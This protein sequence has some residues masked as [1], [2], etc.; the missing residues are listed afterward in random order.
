MSGSRWI[1]STIACTTTSGRRSAAP[2]MP[3]IAVRQRTHRVEDVRHRADAAVEG[4]VRLGRGRVAVPER[5]DDPARRRRGRPAR[6]RPGAPA[7]SVTSRTGPASSRRS[8]SVGSGS[9]RRSRGCVPSRCGEMKGPSRWAPR[10]RAPARM[11]R[12]RAQRGGELV[13]ARRDERRQVAGDA[14]LE[15][16]L[17]RPRRSRPRRRRGSRRRANPFTCRSTKPGAAM[18]RPGAREPDGG[19]AAVVDRDVAG[20][21]PPVDAALPRLR[22]SR[23]SAF[24]TTPPAASSRARAVVGVDTGEQRDDRDARVP[25]GR[26]ERRLDPLVRLAGGTAR[27]S[28]ARGRGASRSSRRRRP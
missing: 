4:G 20:H 10:T 23:A 28:G 11:R 6:A 8:S 26:V 14:R 21:E 3:G 13:L 5:D 9:R 22:A 1:P 24:R 25:A 17:T 16:R 12:D 15:Q 2:T 7:P 18:P 27:R 19:H